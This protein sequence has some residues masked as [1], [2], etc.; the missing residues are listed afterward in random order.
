MSSN[1]SPRG[2]IDAIQKIDAGMRNSNN[3]GT[4]PVLDQLVWGAASLGD[5]ATLR[6]LLVGRGKTT[7]APPDKLTTESELSAAGL[8][9]NLNLNN[10]ATTW[11]RNV[12]NGCTP[13]I[14][15]ACNGDIFIVQQLIE[16]GADV[17][18][19]S[20]RPECALGHTPLYVAAAK[21]HTPVIEQ[22]IKAGANVCLKC[23]DQ[24][25]ALYVAVHNC[26]KAS[27]ILLSNSYNYTSEEEAGLT[28]K[29]CQ[30][31]EKWYYEESQ[32]ASSSE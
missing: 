31:L 32:E 26:H 13:L 19:A 7:W 8:N 11:P 16:A 14:V 21:G 15:A 17:N 25:T 10:L 27:A 6:D 29:Q 28:I 30:L 23:M 20:T 1:S 3:I 9:L 2:F 18:V 22:L 24:Y 5:S 4:G 12:H